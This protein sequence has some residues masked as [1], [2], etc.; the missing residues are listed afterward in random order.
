MVRSRARPHQ[1]DQAG[2]RSFDPASY[3]WGPY[4]TLL[5]EAKQLGWPVLL[6]VTAPAPRWATAN[7]KAPYI[8][9]PDDADFKEF[10]T[11]VD[12][13]SAPTYWSTP[14]WNKHDE[15]VYLL[16]RS[17]SD[18]EP[19]L[20]APSSAASTG[21]ATKACRTPRLSHPQ[22]LFHRN[23]ADRLRHRRP[24]PRRRQGP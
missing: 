6:T 18:G 2:L 4:A 17:R 3:N 8:T 19:S 23:G 1:R 15:P 12:T 13:S 5:A 9:R 20:R 16:P 22:M 14:I 24:P 21:P 7:L 11:A 10:M